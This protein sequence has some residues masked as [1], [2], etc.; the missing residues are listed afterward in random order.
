[1]FQI[2]VTSTALERSKQSQKSREIISL[3][4]CLSKSLQELF[5]IQGTMKAKKI[6]VIGAGVSG[7]GAIKCCLEEGLEPVCFEKS[8]DIG[9]LWKYKVIL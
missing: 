2:K 1:M 6:A 9:G 4:L 8:N 5:F 7:L 3:D